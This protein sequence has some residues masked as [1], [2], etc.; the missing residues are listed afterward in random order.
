MADREET[1]AVRLS[2]Q[3][4][5]NLDHLVDLT[6]TNRSI[7]LRELIPSRPI[8]DAMYELANWQ[9]RTSR[10]LAWDFS[11]LFS[12]N[13]LDGWMKKDRE[14]PISIQ[15]DIRC[16]GL[17]PEVKTALLFRKWAKAKRGVTGYYFDKV[18]YK[19]RSF[20][21]VI[22]PDDTPEKIE[23]LKAEVRDYAEKRYS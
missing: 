2:G 22:G 18:S 17:D 8:I 20:N 6:G 13:V 15:V 1:V 14:H 9:G 16:A 11:V 12:L 4:L 5:K 10:F 7:I 3:G 19:E 21:I 23:N